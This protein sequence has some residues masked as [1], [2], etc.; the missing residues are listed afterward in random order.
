MI[1]DTMLNTQRDNT[2]RAQIDGPNFVITQD[3]LNAALFNMTLTAGQMFNFSQTTTNA[4]VRSMQQRY[5]F[6]SPK[7]L[8]LPYLVCLGLA[9][10]FLILGLKSLHANGASAIDGGFLQ[11][12]MT[13]LGSKS[14]EQAAAGG[15][16]GGKENVPEELKKL[17]VRFGEL[18]GDRAIGNGAEDS[19]VRRRMGFGTSEGLVPRSYRS[20]V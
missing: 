15:S 7:A 20:S 1:A 10:P 14:L 8:L 2:T 3:L 11:I 12:V 4:A 17:R 19:T 5:S 13:T 16:R 6:A 9:I 18:L